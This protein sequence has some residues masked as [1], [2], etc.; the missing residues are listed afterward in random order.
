MTVRNSWRVKTHAAVVLAL[1]GMLALS[2][3]RPASE[4]AAPAAPGDGTVSGMLQKAAV[5]TVTLE[6]RESGLGAGAPWRSQ[7]SGFIL[8]GLV[9]TCLHALDGAAR[10]DARLASG[11][12][13]PVTALRGVDCGSDLVL[14]QAEGVPREQGLALGD[15]AEMRP[16]MPVWVIGSPRGLNGTVTTG[17]VSAR[18][19]MPGGASWIQMTAALSEGSSGSPVLNRR[20]EVVGVAAMVVEGGRELFFAV[21]AAVLEA[22]KVAGPSPRLG[23]DPEL[24]HAGMVPA[25]APKGFGISLP[26]AQWER[27]RCQTASGEVW[28]NVLERLP[29]GD[30][31]AVRS[32]LASAMPVSP[33]DCLRLGQAAAAGRSFGAGTA[34]FVAEMAGRETVFWPG[35]ALGWLALGTSQLEAGQAPA[36]LRSFQLAAALQPELPAAWQGCGM[37][38]RRLGRETEAVAA[39]RRGE[40]AA[41]GKG[42]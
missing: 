34:G 20:G 4:A 38:L 27:R 42:P 1:A 36:A 29:A 35:N 17:V 13:V 14:L 19:V 11:E 37:T 32:I 25:V 6:F 2:G 33:G 39:F 22:M 7:A 40:A 8:D 28:R 31:A 30:A 10:A 23:P 5:G 21:P 24:V 15:S 18:R 3:C 41:G 12:K 9:V 16:G 26:L